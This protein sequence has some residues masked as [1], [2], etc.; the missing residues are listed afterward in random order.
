[1]LHGAR[2]CAVVASL[3]VAIAQ[4]SVDEIRSLPGYSG[5]LRSKHYAG[6]ASVSSN[7]EDTTNQLF[8]YFVQAEEAFNDDTPTLI[9]LNGGP[10]ASSLM[11]FFAENLGPQV[12]TSNGS[13]MENPH[14]LSKKY[15]LMAV[16]NPVGSG[17]SY[18]KNG[19]YVKS[20]E[21][22]RQQFVQGL[23]N[24]F[25]KHPELLKHP[26]WVTGESYAGKYIPNIVYELH[27][28]IA[29]DKKN[30][31]KLAELTLKG[32]IIGNGLYNATA[33]YPSVGDFAYGAGVIDD[34]TLSSV[35]QNATKC[36]QKIEQ[37]SKTAGD[38]CENVTVRWLYNDVVHM[39]MYYDL[40]LI[41]LDLDSITT[42]MGSWLNR[43]DVKEALHVTGHTWVNAD[44]TGPVAEAL[45]DD[46]VRPSAPYVALAAENGYRVALYNGVRDGSVC[47]HLGNHQALLAMDK[48]WKFFGQYEAAN[49]VPMWFHSA[50]KKPR[51]AGF[52][53]I[54]GGFSFTKLLNTGH[55]VPTVI[56]DEFAAFIDWVILPSDSAS[57]LST[58]VV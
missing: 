27:Q 3:C 29:S 54:V 24:F 37:K 58:V 57:K 14:R 42:F 30:G 41:D 26:L 43:D 36:L 46:F 48:T 22:M 51:V 4:S 52:H 16:D 6:Y 10:G 23:R 12:I 35:N 13:V 44:E 20:E 25:L 28:Q 49:D 31:G 1:M 7:P 53:K 50:S 9:W 56:P 47:N 15:N 18:T 45:L 11:G 5:Q 17:F 2:S 21:E 32:M 39:P 55:L 8:Y 40:G 19:A 33:S 34:K 38:Y